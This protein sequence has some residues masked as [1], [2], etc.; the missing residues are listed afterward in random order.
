MPRDS[1]PQHV[2]STKIKRERPEGYTDWNQRTLNLT[3]KWQEFVCGQVLQSKEL[4]IQAADMI[5]ITCNMLIRYAEEARSELV[6]LN[7]AFKCI[8]VLVPNCDENRIVKLEI[9]AMV[10]LMCYS[11]LGSFLEI[12]EACAS[13]SEVN[14][15]YVT[16]RYTL[17]KF[18]ISH[19][20][21]LAN[22]LF[23]DICGSRDDTIACRGLLRY[24]LFFMRSRFI[25]SDVIK[26]DHPQVQSNIVKIVHAAE[27]IVMGALYVS[28]RASDDERRA[29]VQEFILSPG[30]RGAFTLT[31][32]LTE[33]EWDLGRL[34]FLLKTISLFDEFSPTLQLQLY[35]FDGAARQASLLDRV[36]QCVNAIGLREFAPHMADG[37]NH[38]GGDLYFRV[39]S[40]LVTFAC[41]LQPKQFSRLQVDMVGL[42]L[43]Q[44]DL[45]SLIAKDWWTCISD[46]L[47]QSFTTNQVLVFVELLTSLPVG[48]ASK[49]IGALLRSMVPL[50]EEE[51]QNMLTILQERTHLNTHTLLTCFPYESLTASNLDNL[52]NCCTDGWRSACDLL[53]DERLVL[54]A[55]YSM[56]QYVSCLAIIIGKSE[57]YC[58]LP[59]EMRQTLLMW[60]VEIAGGVHELIQ[61]VQ[62]QDTV[63]PSRTIEEIFA[64]LTWMPPLSSET[65]VQVKIKT[66]LQTL[67]S[68][69]LQDV[70][71]TVI[72]ESIINLITF[73]EN[74]RYPRLAEEVM[75]SCIP[76]A[77]RDTVHKLIAETRNP[78]HPS[79]PGDSQT[80][81]TT[82]DVRTRCLQTQR[83]KS[84]PLSDIQAMSGSRPSAAACIAAMATVSRYFE[85]N[86]TPDEAGDS[87]LRDRLTSELA[88]LQNLVQRRQGPAMSRPLHQ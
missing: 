61:Q 66:C 23:K 11:I 52:V 87:K 74:T 37:T 50:L 69:L 80:F 88:R 56:H 12:T 7:L 64:F 85:A 83:C 1:K 32:S 54:E 71:W 72:H 31:S 77:L 15:A 60:S 29:L 38:E 10:R 70:E 53:T 67:F 19:F 13:S 48:R 78:S 16:R 75:L 21:T 2:D 44:S 26:R 84:K 68:S 17:A 35:P 46:R 43:G 49:N 3:K 28:E 42:A 39:L 73:C 62:G 8:T 81:W 79:T 22:H 4:R 82:I 86:L 41:L 20:R 30:P 5:L 9:E 34:K 57:R 55:L 33:Y 14:A 65:L 45:W 63:K 36:V 47:G 6:Y 24:F 27:D 18:Y 59:S 40:E 51:A 76:D 58:I 25:S